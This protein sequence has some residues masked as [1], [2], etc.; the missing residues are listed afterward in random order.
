MDKVPVSTL[1][2]DDDAATSRVSLT[3]R[4]HR[5]SPPRARDTPMHRRRRCWQQTITANERSADSLVSLRRPEQG[6]RGTRGK[7]QPGLK[8]FPELQPEHIPPSH[9]GRVVL[10]PCRLQ[11][12]ISPFYHNIAGNKGAQI[13][14]KKNRT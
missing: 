11:L 12:P 13:H 7:Y 8:V 2:P 9:L 4:R 14:S 10:S 1:R 3:S 5:I 6:I